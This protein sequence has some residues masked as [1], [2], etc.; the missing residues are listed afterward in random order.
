MVHLPY[1]VTSLAATIEDGMVYMVGHSAHGS[2]ASRLDGTDKSLQNWNIATSAEDQENQNTLCKK[3]KTK[4]LNF[5][6]L[7]DLVYTLYIWT[8][9]ICFD[10]V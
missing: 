5:F 6:T 4:H 10:T 7:S 8:G 1:C 3:C 9:Y 2:E